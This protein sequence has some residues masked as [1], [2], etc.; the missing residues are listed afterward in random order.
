MGTIYYL[1]SEIKPSLHRQLVIVAPEKPVPAASQ[2]AEARLMGAPL[3]ALREGWGREG[4]Q[5]GI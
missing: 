2:P 5:A 1:L 4:Q 3:V